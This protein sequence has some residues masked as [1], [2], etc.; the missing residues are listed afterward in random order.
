MKGKLGGLK[1]GGSSNAGIKKSVGG[2]GGIGGNKPGGI[3][4]LK[5]AMGGASKPAPAPASAGPTGPIRITVF[6]KQK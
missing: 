6:C 4:G 5:G 1:M 3:G 2:I